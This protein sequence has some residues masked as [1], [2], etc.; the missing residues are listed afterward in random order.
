MV[1]RIHGEGFIKIGD[2]RQRFLT[3]G[4]PV[5]KHMHPVTKAM[6]ET[7]MS[8][9]NEWYQWKPSPRLNPDVEVLVSL[10]QDNYPFGLKDILPDG[11]CPVVWTNRN[12]RMIYMNMGHG[13]S[14]FTDPT[15][16]ALII[17]GFRWVVASDKNGNVFEE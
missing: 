13:G 3:L 10:S 7:F 17:A 2:E 4:T 1:T 12:Y 9:I 5:E 8:P 16:N 11:D 14:I 15:Q 6:P